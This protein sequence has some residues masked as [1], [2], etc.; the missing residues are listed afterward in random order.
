MD[1]VEGEEGEGAGARQDCP[2]PQSFE[3]AEGGPNEII[4]DGERL[5]FVQGTEEEQ[6][7][8]IQLLN[9]VRSNCQWE[10]T[11]PNGRNPLRATRPTVAKSLICWS[12]RQV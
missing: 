6:A 2:A 8:I 11:N 12:V 1:G 7:A 4:A 3:P 10:S 9:S 5:R